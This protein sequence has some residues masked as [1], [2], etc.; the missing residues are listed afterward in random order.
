MRAQTVYFLKGLPASG[1]STW[2]FEK[3]E[4]DRH[5]GIVTKRV[6]KD[7]LRAMMDNSN[8][9]KEREQ[10]VLY[11]RDHIISSAIEN[12]YDVIVDD[13]NFHEKHLESIKK[14]IENTSNGT[15]PVKI[16]QRFFNTSLQEC[17]ERD[18]NRKNPVGAKVIRD[19]YNKYLKKENT[20]KV[21]HNPSLLDCIIVDVDGTLAIRGERSPYEYWK[22]ENDTLNISV[23]NLVNSI[24]HYNNDY[25]GEKVKIIIM[26]GRENLR[27][28]DSNYKFQSIKEL[29]EVWLKSNFI[30]FDEIYIRDQGDKRPDYIVKKEMYENYV[31]NKYNVDYVIDDRKQVI[32]MWRQQG[33]MVLD[34]AGNEF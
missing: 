28:V 20:P 21:E 2:A 29:T 25:Y 18:A 30:H 8:H 9:S 23:A 11:I 10:F 19:M 33:L 17:I 22:A 7:E 27:A 6:N 3:I 26:T 31:K 14:I 32:D 13:T 4:E 1:K 24:T 5:N 34:V 16:V 15:Q 12:G